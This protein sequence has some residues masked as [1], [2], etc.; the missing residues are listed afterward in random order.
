MDITIRPAAE[1]D[2]VPLIPLMEQLGYQI[3]EADLL[4]NVKLHLKPEYVLFV[5]EIAGKLIGFISIHI[6]QYPH[7]K[8]SLSRITALCVDADYR[9]FGIG[10][11][12]LAYAEEYIKSCGCKIIELTSGLQRE[13]AHRFYE[14]YGYK[15]KRKRFVKDL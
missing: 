5:A 7:L 6:Y 9:S 15:E 13:D 8:D 4:E 11:K 2:V 14:K 3:N 1:K 10:G 12:L